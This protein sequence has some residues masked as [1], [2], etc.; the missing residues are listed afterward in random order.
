[1]IDKSGQKLNRD[2]NSEGKSLQM[3][4]LGWT[5]RLGFAPHA[6]G[7]LNEN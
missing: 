2:D 3:T 4:A 1:M 7:K 6:V 5:K